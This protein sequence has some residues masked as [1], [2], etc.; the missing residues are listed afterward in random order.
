MEGK[1]SVKPRAGVDERWKG[2]RGV[3]E[4]VGVD[5]VDVLRLRVS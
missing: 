2:V 1:D 4:G 3:G 5:T